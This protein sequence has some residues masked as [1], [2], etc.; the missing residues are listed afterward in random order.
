[1]NINQAHSLHTVW[2]MS[3]HSERWA[4]MIKVELI[5]SYLW[6]P[7]NSDAFKM[8]GQFW[9]A[10]Q[11]KCQNPA[12]RRQVERCGNSGGKYRELF[13]GP[14][15]IPGAWRRPQHAIHSYNWFSTRDRDTASQWQADNGAKFSQHSLWTAPY[16]RFVERDW[17]FGFNN[18]TIPPTLYV[19]NKGIATPPDTQN[20]SWLQ[21]NTNTIH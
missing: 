19:H 21:D 15:H 1:M 13:L 5:L 7:N 2:L 17:W 20:T 12:F 16:D 18:G 14:E 10:K 3:T 11:Q 4:E 8:S 9:N 6:L